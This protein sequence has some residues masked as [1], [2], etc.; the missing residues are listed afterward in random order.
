MEQRAA[1]RPLVQPNSRLSPVLAHALTEFGSVTRAQDSY[2]SV[3]SWIEVSDDLDW[4]IDELDNAYAR[5]LITPAEW[6]GLTARADWTIVERLPE[7]IA[8]LKAARARRAQS[9][10]AIPSG[11]L[12]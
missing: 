9:P 12:P 11:A 5:G 1:R 3:T 4:F 2:A 6:A 10:H 7:L 8:L